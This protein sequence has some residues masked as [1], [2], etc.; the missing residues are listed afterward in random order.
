MIKICELNKTY[1]MG[2][3]TVKALDNVN[4]TVEK[5]EFAAIVGT[6]GSGKTTLMN[7]IGC[8]DTHYTAGKYHLDGQDVS[9]LSGRALSLIRN[10]RIGF[11]FQGFNL[12]P[13]L[14]AL[15]NVELPLIYRKTP[16]R[17]VRTCA[18]EALAAVGLSE[19]A[20]HKPSQ[21]SGGQQQRVA[22]ARAIAAEP[23]IILADE[24]CGNLDS[25][26]GG[27]VMDTLIKLNRLG[28]TI[29][30]ITHDESAAREAMRV[31][32]LADGRVMV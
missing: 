15:E 9:K 4:F 3:N 26:S 8:L 13:T 28:R 6:S 11:I 17:E 27:Q 19:R 16:P 29:V 24:P 18:L 12:V 5:G 23:D 32:R 10:R 31:I 20:G 21:L 7:I 25:Q 14:T 30:L 2:D 22:I 1:R